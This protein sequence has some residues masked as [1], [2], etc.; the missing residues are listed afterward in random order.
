MYI[1]VESDIRN[2]NS[3]Q[4]PKLSIWRNSDTN[5]YIFWLQSFLFCRLWIW[6][7]QVQSICPPLIFL[8]WFYVV[9]EQ[10]RLHL[11]D[12]PWRKFRICPRSQ[13]VLQF[14]EY[15]AGEA[16]CSVCFGKDLNI[17]S[18]FRFRTTQSVRSLYWCGVQIIFRAIFEFLMLGAMALVL[19]GIIPFRTTMVL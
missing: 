16:I 2:Q 10:V 1:S 9:N 4:R 18:Q 12:F 15:S 7:S 19:L 13:T 3:G 6:C 17:C 8:H 5:R 11:R 14:Y